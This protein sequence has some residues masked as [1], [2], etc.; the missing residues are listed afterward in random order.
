[1]LLFIHT[2]IVCSKLG[3]TRIKAACPA[4]HITNLEKSNQTLLPFQTHT[5]DASQ[6]P[7]PNAFFTGA[8]PV[9]S[10]G[11]TLLSF[12]KRADKVAQRRTNVNRKMPF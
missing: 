8:H 4:S 1:M 5:T 10:G 2:Q 7:P 12:L 11:Q 3:N 6:Q 9:P